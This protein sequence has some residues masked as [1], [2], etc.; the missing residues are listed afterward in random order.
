MRWALAVGVVLLALLAAMSAT[1]M[2][3]EEHAFALESEVEVVEVCAPAGFTD[4]R[5]IVAILLTLLLLSPELSEFSVGSVSIKRRL[6][7]AEHKQDQIQG[8]V[9]GLRQ[10]LHLQANQQV[11][12]QVP[13]YVNPQDPRL[14]VPLAEAGFDV[15]SSAAQASAISIDEM[16]VQLL[17]LFERLRLFDR[18]LTRIP[19]SDLILRPGEGQ[20]LEIWGEE[21]S[22]TWPEA[23]GLGIA[24]LAE[25][26][27]V[28][29]Q[30]F[31]DTM[32]TIRA[33]RNAIAHGKP[34]EDDDLRQTFELAVALEEWLN[35]QIESHQAR[36]RE[37]ER[38]GPRDIGPRI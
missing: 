17:G 9:E 30:N 37:F 28:F 34:V 23:R 21:V 8:E 36:L 5:Y 35:G 19:E 29:T 22:R 10:Q 1:L 31:P 12:V 15:S 2:V 25:Q 18:R 24:L 7:S 38:D 11:F 16:K 27:H 3:C 13:T 14:V 4:P 32:D 20:E 33:V 26:S 6:E